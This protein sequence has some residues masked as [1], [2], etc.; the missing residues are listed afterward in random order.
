MK[1]YIASDHAGYKL[2]EKIKDYL[3]RNNYKFEDFGTFS[4]ESVDYPEY[5]FKVGN[6]VAESKNSK[7]ILIC[8][9]GNGMAIAANKVN[10]VRAALC[11]DLYTAKYSRLHNNAN[12]L[13]LR[14]RKFKSSFA[15]RIVGVWLKTK[16][17]NVS[18]HKRRVKQI[19]DYENESRANCIRNR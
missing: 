1:I 5:A 14:S 7:G 18:R 15:I 19:S 12:I 9:S 8:G 2:K 13:C 17:T 3:K 4:T 6:A 16:F 11:Y 10:G